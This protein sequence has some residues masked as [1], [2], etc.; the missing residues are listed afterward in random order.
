MRAR[1]I[2][3]WRDRGGGGERERLSER[4]GYVSLVVYLNIWTLPLHPSIR[5]YFVVVVVV[6]DVTGFFGCS[7]LIEYVVFSVLIEHVQRFEPQV[8]CSQRD[9]V[10]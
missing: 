1:G 7:V 9:S 2:D 10:F 3:R 8:G 4:K 5:G 6:F